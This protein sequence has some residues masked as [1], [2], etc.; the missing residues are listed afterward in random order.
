MKQYVKKPTVGIVGDGQLALM[1][2]EALKRINTPFLCLSK[3]DHSPMH[4]FF[5]EA[6]TS[7]EARFR[8]ECDVFSLENEFHTMVELQ[9][10]LLEKT[11][12]LFP[13][14]KSYSFFA[15]KISQRSYYESLGIS[16]PKWLAV[17]STDDV[18]MV[19]AK[20][21]FPFVVK[22]SQGGYDGK[23][24]RIVRSEADFNQVIEDFGLLS[25]NQLLIEEKVNIVTEVAQGFLRNKDGQYTF[26][27]LVETIQD[28][29]ICNLVQYPATVS[30]NVKAQVEFYLERLVASGLIGI[31]NFEF[32]VDEKNKV[33][34]NEGAPR[35]HNSQHLTMDASSYSQFDLLALYLTDPS[36]AP[37]KVST[38]PSI[39]VNILGKSSGAYGDLRIPE[40][41]PLKFSKK[42]YGKKTSS[43]GRKMGHV[44]V[45]DESGKTDLVSLGRK[46]L[47]EY[48]L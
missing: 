2:A 6:I 42:L 12:N 30:P 14:I 21:D 40:V 48:E 7:D 11:Q 3:S 34:I 43:P 25:G 47:K 10:L 45:V 16:G 23:G 15:D 13:D 1:L 35:T 9:N 24:V 4:S 18:K 17:R 22:A 26:L 19:K 36:M 41:F 31:F 8:N 37:R 29:G 5:P 39:M 38:L 20:F 33:M 46:I 28:N 27:P 32:F 44:N